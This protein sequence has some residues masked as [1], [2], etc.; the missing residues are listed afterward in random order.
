M[1]Q[2]CSFLSITFSQLKA[3]LI[4]GCEFN[5]KGQFSFSCVI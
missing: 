1:I 4:K 2:I 3:L 5:K